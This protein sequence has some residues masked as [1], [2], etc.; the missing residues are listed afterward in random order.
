MTGDCRAARSS[1][2]YSTTVGARRALDPLAPERQLGK[3]LHVEEVRGPE[4]NIA[5]LR[6]GVDAGGIDGRLDDRP[7]EV[8]VVDVDHAPANTLSSALFSTT[9]APPPMAN[10][11]A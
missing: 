6:A 10:S 1:F 3:L 11:S 9:M 5:L 2:R 8:G 7:C 4:M